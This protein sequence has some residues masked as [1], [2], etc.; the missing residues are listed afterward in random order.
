MS[1][2]I[3]E[4][5]L[6]RYLVFPLNYRVVK[7]AQIVGSLAPIVVQVVIFAA[8]VA[9][10]VLGI[11]GEANLTFPGVACARF[12]RSPWRTCSST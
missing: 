2:D 12:S 4:G 11:A 5:G 1:G 7:Y 6:N 8:V 3:Y 9:V 10:P